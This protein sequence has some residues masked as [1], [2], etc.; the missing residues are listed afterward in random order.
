MIDQKCEPRSV[1][2]LAFDQLSD[3]AFTSGLGLGG[4]NVLFGGSFL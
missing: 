2:K 1:R 3:M 4:G